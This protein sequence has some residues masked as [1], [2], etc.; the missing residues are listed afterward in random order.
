M[1]IKPTQYL[2]V[3]V[4]PLLLPLSYLLGQLSG[5]PDLST[6]LTPAVLYIVVPLLDRMLGVDI[7]NVQLD[8]PDYQWTGAYRWLTWLC[9][10]VQCLTLFW[11]LYILF[12]IQP[13]GSFGAVVWTIAIGEIGGILAINVAHELIHKRQRIDQIIGGLLLATVSYA[14]FKVEHVRGHHVWVATP[15]DPSTARFNQS[16]YQFVPRAIALNTVNAWRLEAARLKNLGL[17]SWHW[18]NELIWFNL[19]SL[20]LLLVCAAVGGWLGVLFFGV[21][22]LTAVVGL[23]VINYVEHYG[24]ERQQIQRDRYERPTPAHSWNASQR[25]TNALLFQL[26]RHSDHHANAT[27]PYPQLQHHS[28]APQLPAG[29]PTMYLLA[30][31]PPLWRRVMNPR[32]TALRS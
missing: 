1:P 9:L 23:E 14:G 21:Q 18:R 10:P 12:V 24:L 3:F 8:D 20:L 11:G 25:V 5:R 17:S 27:R 31:V 30:L 29:Y 13:F 6:L 16:L 2:W 7:R 4:I 28:E 26:G 19:L 15:K 22:S 32:V